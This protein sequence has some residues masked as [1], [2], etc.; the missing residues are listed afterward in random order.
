MKKR[1]RI[2]VGS[3]ARPL[4][5]QPHAGRP[6]FVELPFN[7]VHSKR[8]VVQPAFGVPAVA[9]DRRVGLK[10]AQQFDDGVAGREADRLDALGRR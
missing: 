2:T 7:V 1:N 8:R 9:R 5:D 4:V 3:L 6:K 10:R